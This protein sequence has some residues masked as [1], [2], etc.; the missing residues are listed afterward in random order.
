[1]AKS[2]DSQAN[3]H[4]YDQVNGLG[5][6]KTVSPDQDIVSQV[7]H[8]FEEHWEYVDSS[9]H[10]TWENCWLLYNNQRIEDL[11]GYNG[12]TDTFVPITFSTIETMV[13]ALTNGKPK[14][15]FVPTKPGQ[16]QE[17]EPLNQLLDYYWDCDKWG[18]KVNVWLR[19]MLVYGT[20]ILYIYWDIDKPRLINV[21]LRDFFI[22]PR[23]TSIADALYVG[24]RYLTTK[25][26]LTEMQVVDPATG[27]MK[28]R[29]KNLDNVVDSQ[30]DGGTTTDREEK[31]MLMGSTLAEKDGQI[32]V[33]EWWDKDKCYSVANRSVLIESSDNIYKLQAQMMKHT[34]PKGLVPFVAQRDYYDESLF[35]AKGEIEPIMQSQE[36]LNDITNQNNDAIAFAI[37]PMFTL[38]PKYADQIDEVENIPGSVYPF[39]QNT[40]NP[41]TMASIPQDAFQERLNIKNEIRE[42]TAASEITKGN[43]QDSGDVTATE[44]NAQ[45]AQS[46]QRFGVKVTQ[47]ENDGFNELGKLVFAMIKL[48]II[49]PTE[50]PTQSPKETMFD[51]VEFVGEY[52]P[53]VQLDVTSQQNQAKQAASYTNMYS[54]M[55]GNPMVNQEELTRVYF[56]NVTQLE[57]DEIDKLLQVQNPA[58]GQMGIPGSPPGG[59]PPMTPE[60]PGGQSSGMPL[61]F[62]PMVKWS[63]QT[64]DK[65]ISAWK[66]ALLVSIWLPGWKMNTNEP[67]RR[68][69][70]LTTHMKPTDYLK[71]LMVYWK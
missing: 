61:S 44:V 56:T 23:A 68:L 66:I 48:F 65:C 12:I 38:D 28:P 4:S 20:G 60:L 13:S 70:S 47:I 71:T 46:G 31:D 64:Y 52:E 43:A 42:T 34:I 36:L 54:V 41:V 26:Q 53:R 62:H 7:T 3:A 24:R 33:I 50:V 49:K 63:P 19:N 45:L 15:N 55:V 67:L 22:D 40:L 69:H 1:M 21:P 25:E 51:P 58:M 35:Y 59:V 57:P 37:N 17:T 30:T 5:K 18:M 9:Y 32:E 39:E 2:I 29:F 10:D 16:T 11:R 27:E 14:F 8:D 6:G